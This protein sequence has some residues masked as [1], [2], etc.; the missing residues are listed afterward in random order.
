M[1]IASASEA[2]NEPA[3]EIA[4]QRDAFGQRRRRALDAHAIRTGEADA[5]ILLHQQ[6]Q[7]A[8]IEWRLPDELQRR[9][10]RAGVDLRDAQRFRRKTQPVTCYQRLCGLR[11]RPEPVDQLFTQAVEHVDRVDAR[12]A[13]V[14]DEA[15]VDVVAVFLRQA[16]GRMQVDLGRHAERL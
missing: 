4:D 5:A 8:R 2:L 12:Q 11:R 10:L 13:L 1:V 6:Y 15:L 7:L 9:A 3:Q 16:R 14:E